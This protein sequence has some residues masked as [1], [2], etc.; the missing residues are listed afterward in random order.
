MAQIFGM[1][2]SSMMLS[3]KRCESPE[4]LPRHQMAYSLTTILQSVSRRPMRILIHPQ[5]TNLSTKVDSVLAMLVRHQ[6]ASNYYFSFYDSL[7]IFSK[8]GMSPA[9]KTLKKGA[10]CSLESN[11]LI[12]I[13]PI[14]LRFSLSL[15]IIMVSLSKL[16]S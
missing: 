6:I 7:A 1:A 8:I 15:R 4:I 14:I 9:S 5:S 3:L 16:F 11:Y 10:A 13:R 12:P 2:P